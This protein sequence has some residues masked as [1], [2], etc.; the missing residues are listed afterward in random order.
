MALF[1]QPYPHS[2]EN[3]HFISPEEERERRI[4]GALAFIT[5]SVNNMYPHNVAP[6]LYT[7]SLPQSHLGPEQ[8]QASAADMLVYT[9][10]AREKVDGAFTMHNGYQ[11]PAEAISAELID[12]QN[13]VF[14]AHNSTA[15]SVDLNVMWRQANPGIDKAA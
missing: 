6:E 5:V 8:I 9:E 3:N 13:E 7:E 1:K 12:A 10:R 15:Q 2:P 4:S 14:K 11:M